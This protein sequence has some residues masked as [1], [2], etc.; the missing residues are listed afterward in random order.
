MDR[1]GHLRQ[2]NSKKS[3]VNR[4]GMRVSLGEGEDGPSETTRMITKREMP[5][6]QLN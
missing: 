4:S 5:N 1:P 6:A 2:V 3:G